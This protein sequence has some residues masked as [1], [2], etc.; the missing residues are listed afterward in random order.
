MHRGRIDKMTAAIPM[1]DLRGLIRVLRNG[2]IISYA[3]DQGKRTK[4]AGIVLFF[5]EPA[6]TNTATSRIA[7]MTGAPVVTYFGRRLQNGSYLLE[8]LPPLDHF[9]I[10]DRLADAAR[11][12]R[13]IEENIRQA[14]E[15]YF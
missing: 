1:D 5:G 7:S 2:H 8:I 13:I 11:I 3:P 4:L 14:P 6:V 15:Q 10:D 9:S 12:N